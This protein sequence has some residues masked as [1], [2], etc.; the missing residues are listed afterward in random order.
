MPGKYDPNRNLTKEQLYGVL[1]RLS[2]APDSVKS[3]YTLDDSNRLIDLVG[4]V[5]N[6]SFRV[7]HKTEYDAGGYKR[8]WGKQVL[9]VTKDAG[10][11]VEISL[12]PQDI[13]TATQVFSHEFLH[14]LNPKKYH[15]EKDN[16]YGGMSNESFDKAS[17]ALATRLKES[18][19]DPKK[20]RE[21]MAG[22]AGSMG[23]AVQNTEDGG[24]IRGER[25]SNTSN[26]DLKIRQPS[27][28]TPSILKEGFP[29]LFL[30]A[31]PLI[32]GIGGSV[33]ASRGEGN[34]GSVFL[35]GLASAWAAGKI[36]WPLAKALSEKAEERELL[37]YR[38]NIE[39]YIEGE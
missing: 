10:R 15:Y 35:A 3:Q 11:D 6:E 30:A 23:V 36:G 19:S 21:F 13:E 33:A 27:N 2:S 25:A 39:N 20:Y 4:M 5:A 16:K 32:A 34:N 22:L 9:G 12:S 1:D 26:L 14:A 31:S 7:S 18:F 29:L 38:E 24:A 8:K 37:P 28:T 17:I